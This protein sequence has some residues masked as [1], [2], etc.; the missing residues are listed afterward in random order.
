MQG[1][2]VARMRDVEG[3][4]TKA[5]EVADEIFDAIKNEETNKLRELT[6]IQNVRMESIEKSLVSL[7][8]CVIDIA[9]EKALKENRIQFILPFFDQMERENILDIQKK[10]IEGEGLLKNALIRN[11]QFLSV[12][13]S[14][15]EAKVD[16]IIQLNAQH[17][18][19]SNIFLN[20]KF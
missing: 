1:K 4:Y 14:V 8:K 13:L 5:L 3:A 11:S 17:N 20:E 15:K 7:Q 18:E 6:D 12:V 19:E 16:A 2:L 10:L 9:N